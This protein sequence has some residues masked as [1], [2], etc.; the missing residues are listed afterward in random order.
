M[1]QPNPENKRP[2]PGLTRRE[3][4][5]TTAAG[6]AMIYAAPLLAPVSSWA[7]QSVVASVHNTGLVAGDGAL[8]KTAARQ[9]VD[10][11]LAL[12]TQKENLKDA[13]QAVF[14]HLKETDTIGLK[15]NCISTKCP[16]HPEVSY[17]LAQS[18]I[19]NLGVNP[20]N[21]IIW[22]RAGS[23]LAKTGYT[24]NESNTGVRCLGTVLKHSFPRQIL[25]RKQDEKGGIGYDKTQPIDVGEGLTSNL[26][27]ILTRMC[28]YL[29]NVPV[30]KDHSLAGVTLSMKNHYGSIDNPMNCHGASCDPY[31]AK[32]NAAPQIREK[33][34]L[35]LCDAAIGVSKGGPRGAPDFQ[36]G[37]VLAAFDPVALD[38][39]GLQLINAKR[40]ENGE[41]P[42]TDMAVHIKTAQSLG[43][44]TC[45]PANIILKEARIG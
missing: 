5:K 43:L 6:A 23:E 8:S 27:K 20:N 1:T 41:D 39:T 29:I 30:L 11:A 24:L 9:S 25:R 2:V 36:P 44:G 15:V 26:S 4:I 18:L 21:I 37:L 34:K 32:M 45:D 38:F 33:T 42:V 31:I 7:S 14:P 13:W 22:D 35:F 16:T 19:D 17:A 28:T 40:K 10:K 12:L 3:F